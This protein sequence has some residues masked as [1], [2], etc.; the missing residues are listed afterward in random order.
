MNSYYFRNNCTN[1]VLAQCCGWSLLVM[2]KYRY[3][4]ANVFFGQ[5]QLSNDL[6]EASSCPLSSKRKK[7]K[8]KSTKRT[9]LGWISDGLKIKLEKKTHA[10]VLRREKRGA[11]SPSFFSLS[12]FANISPGEKGE[13]G[14][15]FQ[16][17]TMGMRVSKMTIRVM[18]LPSC[19]HY[20]PRFIIPRTSS[21]LAAVK[22]EQRT[23]T[24]DRI[25]CWNPYYGCRE[26]T[27]A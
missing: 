2:K 18:G 6:I 8:V 22:R 20:R 23:I 15:I 25:F 11:C 21:L 24:K 10:K 14:A 12:C 27:R 3:F 17:M 4:L 1:F 5:S 7:N 19:C 16:C 9:R 26:L 13:E